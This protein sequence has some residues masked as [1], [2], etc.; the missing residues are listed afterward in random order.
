MVANITSWNWKDILWEHSVLIKILVN[1]RCIGRHGRRCVEYRGQIFVDNLYLFQGTAERVIV[2]ASH[3]G[4]RLADI[5]NLIHC[6]YRLVYEVSAP[7]GIREVLASDYGLDPR[8]AAGLLGLN[9]KNAGML[10]ITP[11]N[12]TVETIVWENVGRVLR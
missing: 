8:H 12:Q 3:R 7:V 9:R 10:S 1:Q 2:I 5:A 4:D 6:K 11:K